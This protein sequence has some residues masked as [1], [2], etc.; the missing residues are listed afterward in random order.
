MLFSQ[1][2]NQLKSVNTGKETKINLEESLKEIGVLL[3]EEYLFG[4]KQELQITKKFIIN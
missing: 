1:M 4:V 2:N 3:E